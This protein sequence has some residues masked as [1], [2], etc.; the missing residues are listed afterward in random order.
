MTKMNHQS[1]V[2]TY[3]LLPNIKNGKQF[4]YEPTQAK[5]P[6]QTSQTSQPMGQRS[7][8]PLSVCPFSNRL[9]ISIQS[10]KKN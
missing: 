6:N 10:R 4:I 3:M 7:F 5:Q 8:T 1:I 9:P 2:T